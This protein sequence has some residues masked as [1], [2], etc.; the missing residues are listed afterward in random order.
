MLE[1]HQGSAVDFDTVFAVL[2][3]MKTA[4]HD[5]SPMQI[6]QAGCTL[7][8]ILREQIELHSQLRATTQELQQHLQNAKRQITKKEEQ[9]Q[10]L[11]LQLKCIFFFC[12][13]HPLLDAS[14]LQPH[15]VNVKRDSYAQKNS[16]KASPIRIP[17]V[18][19]PSKT[20][21]PKKSKPANAHLVPG[22]LPSESTASHPSP[23]VLK[24]D[25]NEAA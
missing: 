8:A 20:P 18:T 16:S 4:P 3:L 6:K 1:S 13:I 15:V 17:T 25:L 9:V 12:N 10:K 24:I 19:T 21:T 22:D 7:E 23:P 5:F 11:E 2:Q 14:C